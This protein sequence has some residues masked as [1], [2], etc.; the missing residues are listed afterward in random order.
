MP[1]YSLPKGVSRGAAGANQHLS[2]R[3][4]GKP[5]VN[6]LMYVGASLIEFS[7]VKVP[8]DFGMQLRIASGVPM[9]PHKG[10]TVAAF[11]FAVSKLLPWVT[12]A[13]DHRGHTQLVA[14]ALQG[15]QFG[16]LIDF[17]NVPKVHTL[18]R[19]VGDYDAGHA[20]RIAGARVVQDGVSQL[21]WYDPM[22][23]AKHKGRW[24][25]ADL[26]LP[27]LSGSGLG[28]RVFMTIKGQGLM[29]F[30]ILTLADALAMNEQLK[31]MVSRLS[32]AVVTASKRLQ[33]E[34]QV[35]YDRL[36]RL[37]QIK[38]ALGELPE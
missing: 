28:I 10:T 2:Q 27:Y 34:Q 22:A 32:D 36:L 13:T 35:S 18:R 26:I 15:Q 21:L 23:P 4:D 19:F 20:C 16:V 25:N 33:A 3:V 17:A 12:I 5:F 8:A 1:K 11:K 24:I 9:G 37:H 38:E 31:A 29:E 7:G 14:D 30:P 6:C